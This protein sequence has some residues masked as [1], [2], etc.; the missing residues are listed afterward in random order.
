LEH[1]EA[2]W[3]WIKEVERVTKNGGIVCIITPF[4]VD[5][6]R[7][8]VDCWRILPDGYRFLL[9]KENNFT[10]LETKI[11]NPLLEIRN[12]FSGYRPRL[13]WILKLFPVKIRKKVFG[14]EFYPYQDTYV[15]ATKKT[16]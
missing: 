15:I 7:Y 1:V 2:P 12:T 6:H 14:Y 5:E 13:K 10:I 3:K 11:N 4:S 9:E 8:P 16:V